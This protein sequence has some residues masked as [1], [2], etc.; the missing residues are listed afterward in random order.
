MLLATYAKYYCFNRI[1]E[2][3]EIIYLKKNLFIKIKI[4]NNCFYKIFSNF[5][6]MFYLYSILIASF[7]IQGEGNYCIFF[8]ILFH[9]DFRKKKPF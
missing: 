5:Q 4:N 8:N 9:V 2:K 3:N 1:K 6:F 7:S